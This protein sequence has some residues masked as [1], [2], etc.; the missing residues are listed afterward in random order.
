MITEKIELRGHVIDTGQLGKTLDDVL[1][2]GGEYVVERF[3]LGR[4][5]H[6][7]SYARIEVQA[8]DQ[9]TLREIMFRLT[10]LGVTAVDPKD[11]TLEPAP[12]D[13]V[14]PEGFYASTNLE[15]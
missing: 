3:V 11:A 13:G 15:T 4:T 6:D 12:S 14:F 7:D 1:E 8:P 10:Q 2:A 9:D 5:K